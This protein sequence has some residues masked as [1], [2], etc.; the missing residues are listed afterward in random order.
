MRT[1]GE[2]H[3]ADGKEFGRGPEGRLIRDFM[4][5]RS[6]G[7]SRR[8]HS[9]GVRELPRPLR[10]RLKDVKGQ[11]DPKQHFV[12]TYLQV[13]TCG[14]LGAAVCV[15]GAT[16]GGICLAGSRVHCRQGGPDTL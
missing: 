15:G 3:T 1:F 10:R 14:Q 12:R 5:L 2:R 6:A 11:P 16:E 8:L 9:Q 13:S 4:T 7:C